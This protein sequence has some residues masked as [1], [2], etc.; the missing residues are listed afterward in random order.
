MKKIV[1]III[2]LVMIA[3][4]SC[5]AFAAAPVI[6][7]GEVTG[8]PGDTVEVP[9]IV[10]GNPGFASV[11]ME[12]EYG[13]GLELIDIKLGMIKSGSVANSES[14]KVAGAFANDVTGD[15]TLFIAVFK[16]S[17]TASE[18]D[19][20][21]DVNVIEFYDEDDNNLE[22]SVDNGSITISNTPEVNT[23][24]AEKD[25]VPGNDNNKDRDDKGEEPSDEPQGGNNANTENNEE[26]TTPG[27]EDPAEG[28]DE[29]AS[30]E[31]VVVGKDPRPSD[32][33][34][35]G[36]GIIVAVI[37]VLAVA[38]GAAVFMLIKKKNQLK[39]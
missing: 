29:N 25:N 24:A 28:E 14:G 21:V 7:A 16:I 34:S 3:S 33:S 5:V 9:I 12:L 38:A 35:G 31:G 17:E 32:E 27:T 1:S 23:N 20:S 22:P 2:A 18:G 6:S 11:F 13:S 36:N 19:V 4:I 39:K 10:S 26:T 8:M 30:G 15:G 37:V